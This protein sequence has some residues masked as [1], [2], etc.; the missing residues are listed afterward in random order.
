MA[1][2]D[3]LDDGS[4]TC[5]DECE[6]EE[7]KSDSDGPGTPRHANFCVGTD[8]GADIPDHDTDAVSTSSGSATT[9][10][11]AKESSEPSESAEFELPTYDNSHV[12]VMSDS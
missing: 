12:K 2:L 10:P 5:G 1:R 9:S 3:D 8:I 4:T 6:D 11:Q 7:T